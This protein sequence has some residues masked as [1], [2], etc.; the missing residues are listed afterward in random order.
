MPSVGGNILEVMGFKHQQ[1]ITWYS[2]LNIIVSNNC[3]L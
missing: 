3:C 2:V 1:S